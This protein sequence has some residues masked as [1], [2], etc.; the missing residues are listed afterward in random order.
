VKRELWKEPT[1]RLHGEVYRELRAR[2]L[3]RDGWRCQL[4]G[5]VTNLTVHHQRYRSHSGAD[6]EQN[7]ITLCADCHSEVHHC[8]FG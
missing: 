1:L 3:R 4:C 5:S 7:L 8:R 6:T 2:I